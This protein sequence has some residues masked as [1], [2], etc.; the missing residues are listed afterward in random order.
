[1]QTNFPAGTFKSVPYVLMQSH[2]LNAN[3]VVLYAIMLDE[4]NFY[5]G[6]GLVYSP[7]EE[8]LTK[9][10]NVSRGVIQRGIESLVNIG[11]VEI[12][13][14]KRGLATHYKVNC[15]T[16]EFI[17][18]SCTKI[19]QLSTGEIDSCTK[20]GQVVVSKQDNQLSQNSTGSCTKIGHIDPLST[21][22]LPINDPKVFN[23]EVNR[24]STDEMLETMFI[25]NV[26]SSRSQ[27]YSTVYKHES[28]DESLY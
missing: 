4:Y 28:E 16:Q 27:S 26:T 11:L 24:D 17:D 12:T 3:T 19:G 25:N 13:F 20:I 15:F 7:S 2:N 1:M 14:Q 8:K 5:T 21:L 9:M 22:P 23:A 6:K 10:M 18:S